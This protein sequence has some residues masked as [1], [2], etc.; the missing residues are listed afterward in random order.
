MAEKFYKNG[1][2]F[3]CRKCSFCCGNS[4]GFVYLSKRDLDFLC[5][6]LKM[7]VSGFV[8]TYCR[9]A[10]YYDGGQVLALREKKNFDCIL[11][12]NGCT[13]YEARP[14]QCATWPFWSW[15]VESKENWDEC[16]R[17]CPGMNSGRLVPFE[18][19]ERNRTS[20]EQ[21]TPLRR[22]ETE[23]IIAAENKRTE[24]EKI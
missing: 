11:W 17:D 16:A 19:I 4:P 14:V 2:H 1:V 6:F 22:E 24:A 13:C 12:E 7:S 3:E 21:N 5:G 20:Y 9:W 23:A 8:G 10:D 15:I 18:E